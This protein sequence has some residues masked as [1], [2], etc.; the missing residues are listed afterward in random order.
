M[1]T[2][3]DEMFTYSYHRP[4]KGNRLHLNRQGVDKSPD[5]DYNDDDNDDNDDEDDDED[6]NVNDDDGDDDDLNRC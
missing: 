5:D 6:D 2:I 4:E 1:I 3:N